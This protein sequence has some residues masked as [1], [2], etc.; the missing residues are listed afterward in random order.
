M[1]L[2][3]PRTLPVG[4]LS[5][6][7][8][9]T[10]QMC[11]LRWKFRYVD[12]AYER[13]GPT[14]LVGTAVHTAERDSFQRQIDEGHRFSTSEV[15]DVYSD[16]FDL[17]VERS[18]E[19]V[20]WGDEKPGT[21][22]DSGAKVLPVYHHL[23]APTVKPIA[24][25]REFVV[26]P[27]DVDWTFKGYIDVEQARGL[28][29]LKTRAPSKGVVSSHEAAQDFQATAEL[30]A[31]RAEGE[32]TPEGF[33]FDSLIRTPTPT[34]RHVMSTTTW[35][36]DEVLDL[37]LEQ[38]Y[39]FA[40]EVD[41][42]MTNDVWSGAPPGAWYCSEAYCGFWE[43]CP[44]GGAGRGRVAGP[45]RLERDPTPSMAL[46]ALR[47]T[48][49]QAG[50]TTAAKVGANLGIGTR[51][52]AA[53]LGALTKRGRVRSEQPTK[54]RGAAKKPLRG[55]RRYFEVQQEAPETAA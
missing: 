1:L 44:L 33:T 25:E 38:L 10:G 48:R 55:P 31:R 20:R 19:R 18:G 34:P 50:Y 16:S 35:R 24:V 4:H 22:K 9:T 41:W 28:R 46:T 43:Q 30:F 7:S 53:L 49:V 3:P 54:G 29:D 52:A 12:G 2:D 40:A 15:L 21:V 14:A 23:V 5:V 39:G 42:R 51:R 32:P 6:S 17:N 36:S 11:W 13:T 47:E 8:M 26:R 37:F 45:P 27:A